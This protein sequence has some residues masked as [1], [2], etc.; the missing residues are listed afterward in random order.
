MYFWLPDIAK[1][2]KVGIVV[3]PNIVSDG[4]CDRTLDEVEYMDYKPGF[5][6]MYS[7][8]LGSRRGQVDLLL[9]E[10]SA[11]EEIA[12]IAADNVKDCDEDR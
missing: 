6:T 4:W 10:G 9:M 5:R 1:W 2:W 7:R 8:T 12:T 11:V 3:K